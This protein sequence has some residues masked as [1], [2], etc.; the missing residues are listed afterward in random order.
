MVTKYFKWG[1]LTW[2]KLTIPYS[3]YLG[4]KKITPVRLR[5]T[6]EIVAT[7]LKENSKCDDILK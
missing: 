4:I 1:I 5:V 6:E 2:E 3:K 7:I